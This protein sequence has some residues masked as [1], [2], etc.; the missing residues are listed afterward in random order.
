MKLS[1]PKRRKLGSAAFDVRDN[2]DHAASEL[3][4]NQPLLMDPVSL[5]RSLQQQGAVLADAERW[6]AALAKF[7]EAVRRDPASATAHEQRAQV[8][9]ELGRDF[10]AVQ[11][12]QAGVDADP[13]WCRPIPTHHPQI[14]R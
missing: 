8:L 13:N 2:D 4:R 1:L 11:A 9:L 14:D 6:H 10:E 3:P 12:A 7:D 5:S